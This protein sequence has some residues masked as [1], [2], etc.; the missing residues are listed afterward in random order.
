[1]FE[2]VAHKTGITRRVKMALIF[3]SLSYSAGSGGDLNAGPSL[4]LGAETV[5]SGAN[6]EPTPGPGGPGGTPWRVWTEGVRGLFSFTQDAATGRF[7]KVKKKRATWRGLRLLPPTKLFIEKG[8][9]CTV[10]CVWYVVMNDLAMTGRFPRRLPFEEKKRR[11]NDRK[12]VEIGMI[13]SMIDLSVFSL[14]FI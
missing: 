9:V 6:N 1:M 13:N 10:L 14:S 4:D 11:P 2:G 12:R 5:A 7:S 3:K 8:P